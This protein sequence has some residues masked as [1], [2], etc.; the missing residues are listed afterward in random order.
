MTYSGGCGE[1]EDSFGRMACLARLK[2]SSLRSRR[3]CLA[4][5]LNIAT[6]LGHPLVF[7]AADPNLC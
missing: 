1:R 5:T 2:C 3:K 4:W 6:G 7:E